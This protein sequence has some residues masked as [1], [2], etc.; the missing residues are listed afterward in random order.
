MPISFFLQLYAV[1]EASYMSVKIVYG[2]LFEWYQAI[3]STNAD[4][5]AI[6]YLGT[7]LSEIWIQA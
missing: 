4:L 1:R 7:L 6:G 5:L 2:F 3:I